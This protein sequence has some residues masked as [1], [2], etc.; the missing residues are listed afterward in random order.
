MT[1]DKPI[2]I[3]A[4]IVAAV[5]LGGCTSLGA[6]ARGDV[7]DA[8][9]ARVA[10]FNDLTLDKLTEAEEFLRQKQARL[11]R[12]KCLFPF[13]ALVRYARSSEVN[14]DAVEKHCGLVVES[15]TATVPVPTGDQ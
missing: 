12:A 2:V 3:V 7:T 11:A 14:R 4:A 13:T 10:Q 6:I 9:I 1:L 15:V 8:L 5:L